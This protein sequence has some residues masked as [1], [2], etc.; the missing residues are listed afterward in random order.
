MSADLRNGLHPEWDVQE[1]QAVMSRKFLFSAY[2][3]VQRFLDALTD[4]SEQEDYY[5]N[6]HFAREHV[7]VTIQARSGKEL[8]EADF[9]FARQVDLLVEQEA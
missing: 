5:P 1:R 4:L 6:L 8:Q 7:T 2:S 3:Q 9:A